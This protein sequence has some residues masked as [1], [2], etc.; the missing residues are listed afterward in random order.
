MGKRTGFPGASFRGHAESPLH[1]WCGRRWKGAGSRPLW[2][3]AGRGARRE[4]P[5]SGCYRH[6]CRLSW[7]DARHTD[8][9]TWRDRVALRPECRS[10]WHR[11]E[12]LLG[13]GHCVGPWGSQES[14]PSPRP[15]CCRVDFHLDVFRALLTLGVLCAS[16]NPPI[17]HT[18]A[19]APPPEHSPNPSAGT[20]LLF[21][22]I[23]GVTHGVTITFTSLGFVLLNNQT[24][25]SHLCTLTSP[26]P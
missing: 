20:R 17:I 14:A 1:A 16:H 12:H 22:Y 5:G 2:P 10:D 4:P 13:G 19:P 9:N 6:R 7:Y 8:S 24:F 18:A 23:D 15:L 3:A 25:I 26:G 21:P 11:S